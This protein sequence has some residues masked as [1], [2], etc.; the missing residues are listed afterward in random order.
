MSKWR[1]TKLNCLYVI[2]DVHGM[3]GPLR[4]ILN[5]IL[6]LRKSDGGK[7]MLVMLGDYIDRRADSHRVLDLLIEVKEKYKDQVIMLTG[8]HEDMLLEGI[9]PNPSSAD[10]LFWM[11]NGGEATLAGYVE[12]K[13]EKV[14]NL[15]SMLRARVQDYIP[16]EHLSFMR[17]LRDY[18][19]Y[20]NY[21]FVHGGC[22]PTLPM[23]KQDRELMLFDRSLSKIVV[24]RFH[25]IPLPWER[26]IV[27]GHNG[28]KRKSRPIIRDK[29]MML[30][31]S[32]AGM[33]MVL[34]L[35]SMQA[36]M[37]KEGKRRG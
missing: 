16:K 2:P 23:H 5:R 18:W 33:L 28:R 26:V 25:N 30:D 37:A 9:K 3:Y 32:Y 31:T 24:T 21:I 14:E 4:L 35:R 20:E 7:D 34:E 11:N 22:D 27:T 15:Y 19:E 6:P 17:S 29:F 10:Y 13:G 8:N 12:R 1:P 36:F